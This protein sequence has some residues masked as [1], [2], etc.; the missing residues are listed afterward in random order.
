[1]N[2]QD[3]IVTFNAYAMSNASTFFYAQTI[4]STLKVMRLS[5]N[6]FTLWLT[7]ELADSTTLFRNPHPLLKH[8]HFDT[9][10]WAI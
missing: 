4:Q 5:R 9:F 8:I 3:K 1:M 10:V 2:G 6:I 7:Q